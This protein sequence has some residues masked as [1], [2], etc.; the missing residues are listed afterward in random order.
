M[1]YSPNK[2]RDMRGSS[3]VC[4]CVS[5][6]VLR[7]GTRYRP[8]GSTLYPQF[9]PM[10][11]SLYELSTATYDWSR[12]DISLSLRVS[13]RDQLWVTRRWDERWVSKLDQPRRSILVWFFFPKNTSVLIKIWLYSE[14]GSLLMT[15]HI[16]FVEYTNIIRLS[17]RENPIKSTG[18]I[19]QNRPF[20]A[21]ALDT[22]Y[23][24]NILTPRG[25]SMGRKLC[26]WPNETG[27]D[28]VSS[29]ST[30]VL[31]GSQRLL[32]MHTNGNCQMVKEYACRFTYYL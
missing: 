28:V 26:Q 32:I 4:V 14:V 3:Q 11:H 24:Y 18:T 8:R 13:K 29:S 21:H 2:I 10:Q 15:N 19:W 20:E 1:E 30:W 5:V 16:V 6:C 22:I 17:L 12:S 9:R 7:G 25:H 23:I 27:I 31:R